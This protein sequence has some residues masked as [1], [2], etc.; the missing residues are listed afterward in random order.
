MLS[1]IAAL[2]ALTED[3][4]MGENLVEFADTSLFLEPCK[5]IDIWIFDQKSFISML[6]FSAFKY[7][8]GEWEER[9]IP[10]IATF[11]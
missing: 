8:L 4:E 7:F 9:E 10:N 2:N 6:E 3:S 1:H 11:L 5:Q